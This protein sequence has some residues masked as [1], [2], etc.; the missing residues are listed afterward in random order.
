MKCSCF[1]F[2]R[3]LLVGLVAAMGLLLA[4]CQSLHPVEQQKRPVAATHLI[5]HGGSPL[6]GPAVFTPARAPASS[7]PTA[8]VVRVNFFILPRMPGQLLAPLSSGASLVLTRRGQRATLAF[9]HLT[10]GARFA[11]VSGAASFAHQLT[12][13]CGPIQGFVPLRAAVFPGGWVS[14]QLRDGYTFAGRAGGKSH[15]ASVRIEAWLPR[16]AGLK[17]LQL[18]LSAARFSSGPSGHALIFN[19]ETQ[20]VSATGN[21]QGS[22]AFLLP[23]R[24]VSGRGQAVAAVLHIRPAGPKD[25]PLVKADMAMAAAPLPALTNPLDHLNRPDL[26]AALARVRQAS[27]RRAALIYLAGQ[28]GAGLCDDTALTLPPPALKILATKVFNSLHAIAP[29]LTVARFG[30]LMDRAAYQLIYAM[31]KKSPL[32]PG[33]QTVLALHLGEAAYHSSSLDQIAGALASRKIFLRQVIAENYIYLQDTSPSARIGAFDWL[34]RHHFAPPGYHPLDSIH[35]RNA[36]LD[37][38][39]LDPAFLKRIQP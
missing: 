10:R 5:I 34:K 22:V 31:Q 7:R 26:I 37:K 14:F 13:A 16:K 11:P 27:V 21:R 38:A 32:A 3:C 30:W 15:R 19:R 36:A 29:Q 17:S 23:F 39:T 33:L 6:S 8:L 28:T 9:G 1:Q 35:S 24:F 12:V 4:G 18:A 20:I 25:Q 2:L